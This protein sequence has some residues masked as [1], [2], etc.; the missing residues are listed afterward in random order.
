[1]E[2]SHGSMHIL[3]KHPETKSIG[4]GDSWW[5]S[6]DVDGVWSHNSEVEDRDSS[7][8]Q[9][10]KTSENDKSEG[11]LGLIENILISLLKEHAIHQDMKGMLQQALQR[12]EQNCEN[13]CFVF[14]E[15]N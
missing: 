8:V 7:F 13:N 4:S 15:V 5:S 6:D 2:D 3:L 9:E 10:T 11:K 1:M 14:T 12:E